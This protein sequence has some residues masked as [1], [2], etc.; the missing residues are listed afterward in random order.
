MLDGRDDTSRGM[1][2]IQLYESCSTVEE[3][4]C[5]LVAGIRNW[6]KVYQCRGQLSNTADVL[7]NVLINVISVRSKSDRVAVLITIGM[8]SAIPPNPR[9]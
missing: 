5:R 7:Q 3:A 2:S 9:V 6:L 8:A 4:Q 1:A